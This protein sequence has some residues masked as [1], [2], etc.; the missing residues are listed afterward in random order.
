MEFLEIISTT[1]EK[2]IIDMYIYLSLILFAVFFIKAMV[3]VV[4]LINIYMEK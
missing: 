1:I 2:T 3:T 4:K